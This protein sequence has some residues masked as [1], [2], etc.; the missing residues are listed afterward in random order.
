MGLVGPCII[1]SAYVVFK[2]YLVFGGAL[3]SLIRLR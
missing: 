3:C 1:S 2:S